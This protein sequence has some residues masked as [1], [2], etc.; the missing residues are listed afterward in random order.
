MAL[1]HRR[2]IIQRLPGT[3]WPD[4]IDGGAGDDF[5]SG[6]QAT[7]RWPEARE[8]TTWRG[9][10]KRFHRRRFD[11]RFGDTV[12]FSSATT[13]VSADLAA[14]TATDGNGGIDSS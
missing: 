3:P 7:T 9:G 12:Q 5:L 11:G 6:Q 2:C 14:G 10:R 4:V 8:T 13:G 1:D